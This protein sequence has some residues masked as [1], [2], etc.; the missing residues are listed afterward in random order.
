MPSEAKRIALLVLDPLGGLAAEA[1]AGTADSRSE[2][3]VRRT[4]IRRRALRITEHLHDC[5]HKGRVAMQ[6]TCLAWANLPGPHRT[7]TNLYDTAPP[8]VG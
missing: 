8:T 6:G 1:G 5:G 3:T 2:R 4:D 7:V